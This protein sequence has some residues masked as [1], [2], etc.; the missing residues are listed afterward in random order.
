L[1]PDQIRDALAPF[2]LYQVEVTDR[3]EV[4]ADP[5]GPGLRPT[6]WCPGPAVKIGR[7]DFAITGEGADDPAFP[8][9]FPMQVG[10]VLLHAEYEAAKSDL[11]SSASAGGYLDYRLE[12]HRVL[13]DPVAYEA[14]VEFDLDT[15]PALLSGQGVVQA[16]SSE[17]QVFADLRE[18]RARGRLQPDLLL[19][20]QGRLLGTEYFSDVEIVPRKDATDDATRWSRSR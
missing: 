13:I 8:K 7:V 3:L 20:L 17:R 10:D 4:P 9:T 6:P 19:A 12:R 1:A 15:G 2:G 18:F 5:N 11:R 16:G 14:I